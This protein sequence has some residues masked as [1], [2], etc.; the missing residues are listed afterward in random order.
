[1]PKVRGTR[2]DDTLTA[3]SRKNEILYGKAGDDAFVFHAFGRG[4]KFLGGGG[5][6]HLG[7]IRFDIDA[8]GPSF[9]RND[10]TF[11]GG[12]GI[13][14]IAF[15]I[16][17]HTSKIKL[18]QFGTRTVS[19]EQSAYEIGF[20]SGTGRI[21]GSARDEMVVLDNYLKV[22]D[23]RSLNVTLKG[24]DDVFRTDTINSGFGSIRIDLGAGDDTVMLNQSAHGARIKGGKG[25]DFIFG[26]R[27]ASER[28]L[29][30]SGDDTI[31]A[32]NGSIGQQAIDTI[33][34]GSGKDTIVVTSNLYAIAGQG[35]VLDFNTRRD[36]VLIADI[37]A[38]DL[39]FARKDADDPYTNAWTM[40]N[41][42]GILYWSD[43]PVLDFGG[44]TDLTARNFVT[45]DSSYDFMV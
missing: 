23:M 5:D 15:E 25:D 4:D 39:V 45:D 32:V 42:A 29:A 38:A 21:V 43:R 35:Q 1:M 37:G 40:D 8:S 19:V 16:D 14:T 24:G 2:F 3:S 20:H 41:S 6:D 36:T 31:L 26:G 10:I 12:K 34:T 9:S 22:H 30:G 28:I 44:R 27:V 7:G 13:D 33:A 17:V 18:G 11:N